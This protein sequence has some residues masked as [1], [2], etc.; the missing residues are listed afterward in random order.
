MAGA[1]RLVVIGG[2]AG[3]MAAA[4]QAR[5]LDPLLDIVALERG[6]WTSYSACGIPYLVGGL[7][8]GVDDLVAR[9]PEQFQAQGIDVRTRHEAMAIDL[10]AGKVEVR[11]HKLQ[12]T[13]QLGFDRIHL[14]TGARPARPPLPGSDLPFVGGVQTLEDAQHLLRHLSHPPPWAPGGVR[15]VVVVGAGYIGLE[16]AEAFIR[17]GLTV[18]L[19]TGSAEVMPS[20]D[21]DMAADVTRAL[22][23]LGVTVRCDE[24]VTAFEPGA[25][26]SD[27]GRTP[28]DLVVLG[29]GVSPNS[30]LAGAAG[31]ELGVRGAV[32]VDRRQRTSHEAVWA[33]GDCC[34]STHL[35]SGRRLHVA[36]G[37]VA[38]KQGRV[39]GTNLG[40]GYATFAGVL[41]T[42]VTKVCDLEVAR[43][44]LT[45]GEAE[46]AG[47]S[48]VAATVD[49]TTVA[50]YL[51]DAAPIKVKVVAERST[52][53]LL[54]AQIVG[55]GPGSA[56]RIDVV[57]TALTAGMSVGDVADLDLAYAPPFGPLWDPVAIA[58][59][60]AAEAA[61]V[62]VRRPSRA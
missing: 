5:R 44:G 29:L 26:I 16:M 41:G 4:S 39:A 20:L 2:D 30:E 46:A 53:R 48:A 8:H 15:R 9:T 21:R 52:G 33:A 25:V 43:T 47:F 35:V 17:R 40:G 19:L 7:V 45:E 37:T 22:R 50:V 14:G 49:S 23:G 6:R 18:T 42:A 1:R 62:S 58:S 36:L 38:N 28:A 27:K 24:P 34:E 10:D 54:G 56:K 51:P 61:V 13:F 60:K 11:D 59:R 3:G 57:A 55:G 31:L 12:R 32:V